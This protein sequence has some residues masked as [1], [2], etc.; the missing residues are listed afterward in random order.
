MMRRSTETLRR[1]WALLMAVPAHPNSLSTRALHQRMMNAKFDV[2]IRTIQRDLDWLSGPFP[3]VAETRGKSHYWQWMRGSAGLEIPAMSRQTALVFQLAGQYLRGLLPGSVL[4]L[5]DPYFQRA[6]E[7]LRGSPLAKWDSKVMHID[8]GL[9]MTPPDVDPQVRDSV[10]EALLDGLRFEAEYTSRYETKPKTSEI[11]P[12]G[13]A[14]H[15]GVTYLVC[16][17][18]G[19]TDIRQIAL[20]RIR[21]AR[22]LDTAATGIRGFSLEKYV[23]EEAAFN[24]P[25]S[26]RRIRLKA[27]FDE[28][29]A[30]HLTERQLSP[31]QVLKK[32]K[33]GLFRLTATVA[34]TA[35][36]RWWLLGFGDGVEVTGPKALRDEIG[37][38]VANMA[39]MYQ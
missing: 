6:H 33:N 17:F 37:G 25:E 19:Y 27:L 16:T 1:Q 9:P 15:N 30:Y 39:R 20:H 11:N 7:A 29:A 38:M 23:R 3:L 32:M 34:D 5:L 12:L 21:R 8:S 35:Q 28:G 24:Y 2:N 36:L 22:L 10:Y 4:R 31:D 18:W 14:T 13:I 26:P